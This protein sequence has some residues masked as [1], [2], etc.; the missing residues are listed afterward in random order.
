MKRETFLKEKQ[1]TW[2]RIITVQQFL[3]LYRLMKRE[4]LL[5][6][7][8]PE[9]FLQVFL[10]KLDKISVN[11]IPSDAVRIEI[12]GKDTYACDLFFSNIFK[13]IIDKA[14]WSDLEKR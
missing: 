3:S 13:M 1:G 2:L 10:K 14:K 12:A 4:T 7:T 9:I 11:E 6:P 5:S 8:S